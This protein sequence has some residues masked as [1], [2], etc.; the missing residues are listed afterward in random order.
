MC[1]LCANKYFLLNYLLTICQITL[2]LLVLLS[3]SRPTVSGDCD[4]ALSKENIHELDKADLVG[5]YYRIHDHHSEIEMPD[6]LAEYSS[7]LLDR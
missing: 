6:F 4:K 1:L 2:Q 7:R 5:Y 3:L